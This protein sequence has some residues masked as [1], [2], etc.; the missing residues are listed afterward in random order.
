MA[1]KSTHHSLDFA[2]IPSCQQDAQP[3]S[4]G[5][6][7]PTPY[8]LD[9]YPQRQVQELRGDDPQS[10][11]QGQEAEQDDP[12]ARAQQPSWCL[13]VRSM[14]AGQS[15]PWAA[16]SASSRE[17]VV[18]SRW[19]GVEWCLSS[20]GRACK[21]M[22]GARETCMRACTD[23]GDHVVR[24]LVPHLSVSAHVPF[25]AHFDEWGH[26]RTMVALVTRK[27]APSRRIS[28]SKRVS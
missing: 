4:Y 24:A 9:P 3:R 23:R 2:T 15:H 21:Q 20:R 19:R 22:N 10:A 5:T 12:E 18:T 13:S 14:R 26:C 25:V 1:R 7:G 16:S 27:E 28:E 8:P 17:K 11:V 6:L